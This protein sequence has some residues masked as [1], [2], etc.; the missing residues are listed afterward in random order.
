MKRNDFTRGAG[1]LLA[2][3]SLPSS[4]GIGT[5]GEAA[6]QFVDMLVELRQKYWQV[7]P[8]G[9][10]SYGD[11]PYQAYSAFAGNPYMIDLDLLVQDG[12]LKKEEIINVDW[13]DDERDVDYG[14]IYES[15]FKILK[16]AFIRFDTEII[17][18]RN[19][20]VREEAWLEEYALFMA[21]KEHFDYRPWIE[22]DASIANHEEESVESYKK[23]LSVELKF[24]KFLQYKFYTQWNA[25]KGYANKKGIDIIGDI[26]IYVAHDSVDVWVNRKLFVLDEDGSLSLVSGCP[27][28][29]SAT[30]GQKWGNPL[31]DYQEMEKDDFSWWRKRMELNSRLFN[32]VRIDHFIGIVR[33]YMISAISENGL[34]GEWKKGPGLKLAKA[35]EES[36]G[37]TRII[38]ED[39]GVKLPSVIKVL[40]RM[41]WPG[42]M[43][44]LFAFN[45]DASNPS[46][47]HNYENHNLVIYGSTH[48]YQT[49]LGAFS[50]KSDKELDFTY[51]YLGINKKEEIVDSVIRLAY[52]S[53]AD[54]VIFQMQ[55][56]LKLDD[57]SRMN[58]PST[59]GKNWKFRIWRD[60]ISEERGDFIRDLVTTFGR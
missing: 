13:G 44:L 28:D 55:D 31:Y 34:R 32:V 9:P 42:M 2:I 25:L 46:L 53:V 47:P 33:Y 23:I 15:R 27:P 48:D 52:A 58:L 10:T 41:G 60:C 14:K 39:V 26:P 6:I 11:S 22:W 36:S 40:K 37:D 35:I 16:I 57:T 5:L 21:L 43:I 1:V 19:F 3:T 51:K 12:L 50:N 29:V 18:F 56:I 45:G 4:Y 24:W 7:L 20:C 49:L 38:A 54:I 17:E 30:E 59:V 8:I